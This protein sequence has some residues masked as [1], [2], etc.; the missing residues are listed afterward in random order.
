MQ[1]TFNQLKQK[2]LRRA[3]RQQPIAC[4]QIL[5]GKVRNGQLGGFKFKRQFSVDKYVVDFYCAE[6]NLVMKI[7]GAT[8]ES[9]EEVRHDEMRQKFLEEQGLI[10]KRYTNTDVKENLEAVL[11]NILEICLELRA[12]TCPHPC[13]LPTGRGD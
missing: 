11:E 13:P 6:K 3:L 10:V 1:K 5:W 2:T 9:D 12:K 8:H 7:D 4:E